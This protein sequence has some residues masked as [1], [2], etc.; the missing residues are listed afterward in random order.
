MSILGNYSKPTYVNLSNRLNKDTFQP[1]VDRVSLLDTYA[2]PRYKLKS[3]DESVT[4]STALQNDDTLFISL[5]A[6]AV[7]KVSVFLRVFGANAGD[8]KID[9]TISGGL[10]FLTTRFCCG[11]SPLNTA[12]VWDVNSNHKDAS[13]SEAVGYGAGDGTN[14]GCIR[15]DFLLQTVATGV[16]QMRWAQNTSDGTATKVLNGSHIIAQLAV[17]FA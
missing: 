3:A 1:I 9:W 16:L 14:S 13:Y 4:S 15:E 5:E 12:Y 7:W 10:T 17:P 11:I 2:I 6:N 8:I